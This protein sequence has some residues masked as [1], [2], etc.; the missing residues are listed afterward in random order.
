MQLTV[1]TSSC[2]FKNYAQYSAVLGRSSNGPTSYPTLS[3]FAT[4]VDS[5]YEATKTFFR[6]FVTY[7]DYANWGQCDS[8]PHVGNGWYV[9]WAAIG[10]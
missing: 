10:N 1:D 2:S 6:I 5:I 7:R 8:T 4:G 9:S 3:A